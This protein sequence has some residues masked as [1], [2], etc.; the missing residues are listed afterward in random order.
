HLLRQSR[1]LEY[2]PAPED[3]SEVGGMGD[4]KEWLRKRGAAF[5]EAAR[6]FGLPEPRGLLL[7]GVQGGGKS[8]MA[9][10]V[11]SQWK[12]PLLRLDMGRVFGEMVGASESNMRQALKM[13]ERVSP[14]VLW[15]DEI[16]KGLAG[17][18]S[19]GRSDAGTAARVFGTLLTWMQE[20]Q[21]PV[22]VVATSNDVRQLPPE[23]LRK[24]R[25]DEIFFVD[26]PGDDERAEIW[27]IH[28]RKRGREPQSFDIPRLVG[29]TKGFTGAEIEQIIISA[30]YDAFDERRDVEMLDLIRVITQTVPLSETMRDEIKSLRQWAKENARPAGSGGPAPWEMV[31]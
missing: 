24:G 20:K 9:K 18:A 2:F 5:S 12:L 4:L 13:A 17:V 14:S 16:E 7:L 22:F 25:F 8:L 30:L 21:A 23:L 15:T 1:V 10:A 31:A 28:L 27:A 19:S 3:F 6:R 26:L 29:E 11:A